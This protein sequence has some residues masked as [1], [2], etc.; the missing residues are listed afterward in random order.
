MDLDLIK[1]FPLLSNPPYAPFC[2]ADSA[3]TTQKP[4]AVITALTEHYLKNNA[5]VHR[6]AYRL[7][8]YATEQFENSRKKIAKFFGVSKEGIVFCRS[9]T[10]GLNLLVHGLVELNPNAHVLLSRL[11]HHANIVP[12]QE[13]A[14]KTNITIHWVDPDQHGVIQLDAVNEIFK[15][16]P[17]SIVSLI[18]TSNTLGSIQPL[19][20]LFDY[21]K[22][23]NAITIADC[24]QGFLHSDL[25]PE[26]MNADAIVCSSHKMYGP[27]GLG[28]IVSSEKFL[29]SL[30]VYQTGG[31]MILSVHTETTEFMNAPYKFEAGTPFIEGAVGLAAAFDYISTLDPIKIAHHFE[32][33]IDYGLKAFSNLGSFELLIPENQHRAPIFSL[34]HPKIHA[35]DLSTF[36]DQTAGVCARAGHHCTMPLLSYLKKPATYR[37]SYHLYNTV[38][39]IDYCAKALLNAEKFFNV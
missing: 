2:Y 32:H 36:L 15:L 6:G 37:L 19:R 24:C 26:K 17:I 12:W 11:E 9:A 28:L 21:C 29:E 27:S 8:E 4:L 10:E 35:H 25:N 13:A 7:S 14:K 38:D 34:V 23:K 30:P 18:H 16:Y 33:L 3:A 20:E 1:D 31:G 39:D 22:K 5:N